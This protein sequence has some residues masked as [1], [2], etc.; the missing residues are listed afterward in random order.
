MFVIGFVFGGLAGFVFIVFPGIAVQSVVEIFAVN[1]STTG[2]VVVGG[3]IFAFAVK[4]VRILSIIVALI[5]SLIVGI[6]GVNQAVVIIGL[7]ACEEVVGIVVRSFVVGDGVNPGRVIG[8]IVAS[9]GCLL[10]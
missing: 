10:G 5:I 3:L 2:D 8:S 9:L 1:A 7:F 4:W 6:A